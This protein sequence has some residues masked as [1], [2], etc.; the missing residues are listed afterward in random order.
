M[1]IREPKHPGY[2]KYFLASEAPGDNPPLRRNMKVITVNPSRRARLDFTNDLVVPDEPEPEL[3]EMDDSLD[4]D[5]PDIDDGETSV[6]D[7][8]EID[9]DTPDLDL[10]DLDLPD[11]DPTQTQNE[12]DQDL[13]LPDPNGL[14]L[15]ENPSGSSANDL[16]L[17]EID[18]P[19]PEIPDT[20]LD[21][22]ELDDEEEPD[23]E[24]DLPDVPGGEDDEVPDTNLNLPHIDDEVQS[25]NIQVNPG[26]NDG[27]TTDYT[28]TN[29]DVQST[30]IQV[31]PADSGDGTDFTADANNLDLPPVDGGDTGTAPA[32]NTDDTADN[33]DY[34]QQGDDGAAGGA[35]DVS[36]APDGGGDDVDFTQTGDDTGDGTQ[37]PAEGDANQVNDGNQK[38]GPGLEYDSVRKYNLYKEFARL[39]TAIDS[40]ITKL[41]SCIS[42]DPE[43]NHVIK[44]CTTKFR[45]MYDLI[46][47]YMMMKFELCTYI[48]NLLFYQRQ[49]ATVHL[50]FKLLE[51]ANKGQKS[52]K[53]KDK[54]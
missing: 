10:P 22:P 38:R 25:T 7:L 17:P 14:D 34:T 16:D 51:E 31:N 11:V 37:P 49:I 46:T 48:Q 43:S 29:D 6:G 27:D 30:N 5:L 44:I 1:I 3:P 33:T 52:D 20:N 42:D 13:D 18:D 54:R 35:V 53:E 32:A 19:V 36:P 47:D 24:L 39:R 8:P 41:E 40:Y 26:D 23:M 9:D 45:E 50:I 12:P 28:D 2:G 21:L 15:P 4:L